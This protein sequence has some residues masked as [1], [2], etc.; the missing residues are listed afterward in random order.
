MN[1]VIEAITKRRSIRKYLDKPVPKEIIDTILNTV[2]MSPSA[3]N[4][5][6][7]RFIVIENKEK[8]QELSAIVKKQMGLL[9]YALRFTE[10]IQSKKDTIF[11]NAP[12]LIIIAAEKDDKWNK[13]NC[14]IIAQSMFLT[15]YS[16][17]L[18]SCYIGFANTLN[19]DPDTLRELKVPENHE[20]ISPII[21]GYPA[22]TKEPP[23]REPKVINWI[24]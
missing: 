12:L 9:G 19:N 22:D 4:R 7:W 17:G 13:I 2:V 24:K 14:G 21:F 23:K 1:P 15:A 8:I 11:Y 3:M 18:G 16:L 5:Q 6:P 20:I 10:I